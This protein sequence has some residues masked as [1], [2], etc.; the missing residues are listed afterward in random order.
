MTRQAR[1]DTEAPSSLWPDG[2]SAHQAPAGTVAFGTASAPAPEPPDT[3]ALLARGAER[4]EI[5]CTPCHGRT[6]RGDGTVVARGF[7]APPDFHGPGLEA[8]S[9]QHLYDVITNGFGAMYDFGS[10]IAPS[11]RWAIV[12]YIR[13]LQAR[14]EAPEQIAQRP[15]ATAVLPHG[16]A[17]SALSQSGTSR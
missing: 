7:P 17:A 9:D 2:A 15:A 10:R 3:P 12:A 8:A 14:P 13:A 1:Y 4:Y 6:G 11:D 16:A 5:F